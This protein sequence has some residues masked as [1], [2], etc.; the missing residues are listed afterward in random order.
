MKVVIIDQ[1]RMNSTRLP[2]KIMKT[3]MGKPLLEY[4]LE[5]LLRVRSASEV[6]VATTV[7]EAD[8]PIAELCEKL[9]VSFFRGSEEDVLSRYYHAARAY[10]ADVVVRVT[11]D[12]PL[13]DPVVVDR[14][15]AYYL[16]N[17]EQYD[18]I[19]NCRERSFPRGMDTEVLSFQVL[20][21]AYR[22]ATEQ[23][24]REHVTPFVSLNPKRYRLGHVLNDHDDSSHRWTVDTA[25][26]YELIKRIIESLYPLKKEFT[27][28]DCLE[29]LSRHPEWATINTSV[30]HQYYGE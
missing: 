18:Y 15:I 14:I 30:K 23:A 3:V 8:H 25:E 10:E 1:A 29:L 9:Q 27:M 22:F 4:Q 12:C 11:S 6:V 16:D 2:G 19:S 24:H 5:R 7:N 26:D 13:I 21:E 20:E 17:K 28:N